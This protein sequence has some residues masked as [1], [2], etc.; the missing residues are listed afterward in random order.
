MR[1]GEVQYKAIGVRASP[2]HESGTLLEWTVSGEYRC[3]TLLREDS[4]QAAE[5]KLHDFVKKQNRRTA[6]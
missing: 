3:A 2:E 6:E 5:V 1:V 4:L